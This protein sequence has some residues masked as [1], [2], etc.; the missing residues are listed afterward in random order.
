MASGLTSVHTV[1]G[2]RH[3]C[4]SSRGLAVTV[5]VLDEAHRRGQWPGVGIGLVLARFRVDRV[6]LSAAHGPRSRGAHRPWRRYRPRGAEAEAHAR[7]SREI[8][9]VAGTDLPHEAAHLVVVDA[10]E[11]NHERVGAEAAVADADAVLRRKDSG[12]QVV[13][14]AGEVEGQ[15]GGPRVVRV[16]D[17]VVLEA[18]DRTELLLA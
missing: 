9:V 4:P 14:R 15:Q 11:A 16:P 2:T 10:Q 17:A 18:V 13:R 6:G 12:Q 5:R 1:P 7:R 8:R 3:V